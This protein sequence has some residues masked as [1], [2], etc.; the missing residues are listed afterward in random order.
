M[1]PRCFIILPFALF[2]SFRTGFSQDL[3]PVT[4]SA[5]LPGEKFEFTVYYDSF[6]TGKVVAGTASLEVSFRQQRM[7]GREVYHASGAGRSK[8]AF[9]LF[10]KVDDRFESFIDTEY[11]V[12]LYFIRHTR[13]GDYIKDDEVRF[14]HFTGSAS[15]R[16]ASKQVPVGT[17]DLI[18][19]F[20]YARTIDLSGMKP[21]DFFPMSF[22]LDDSVYISRVYY[23]GIEV[24]HSEAGT[25]RCMKFKPMVATGN[26]FT[27]PYPMNVWVT[28]D[29]YRIPVLAQSA[30]IIGSVKLE[31]TGY[32]GLAGVPESMV[33]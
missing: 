21:G 8:G 17:Q 5:F 25:F 11:L 7:D 27:Q 4:N 22:Y 6:L 2:F 23:E 28:D 12:P 29:C 13:E 19:A 14:N 30:V 10:F 24:V 15:S 16:S 20:Y 33:P 26:V 31:L 32:R 9:N 1:R 18:S 3:V